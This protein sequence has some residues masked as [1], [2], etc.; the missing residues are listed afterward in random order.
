MIMN[1]QEAMYFKGKYIAFII[2]LCYSSEIVK[3]L[4]TKGVIFLEVSNSV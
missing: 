3:F 4:V 1:Y 2:V